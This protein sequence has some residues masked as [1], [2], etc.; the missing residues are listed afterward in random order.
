MAFQSTGGVDPIVFG[1]GGAGFANALDFEW[2]GSEAV[3]VFVVRPTGRGFEIVGV[4]GAVVEG[5]V[6]DEVEDDAVHGAGAGSA[7]GEF[8]AFSPG[9]N[10]VAGLFDLTPELVEIDIIEAVRDEFGLWR[11]RCSFL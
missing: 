8:E 11:C 9:A 10:G 3:G 4:V 2:V 7:V 1:A 6:F 5:V